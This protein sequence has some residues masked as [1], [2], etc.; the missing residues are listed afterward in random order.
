[1]FAV[2]YDIFGTV[3]NNILQLLAGCVFSFL[4]FSHLGRADRKYKFQCCS[5]NSI[6]GILLSSLFGILLPFGPYGTLPVII[7]LYM[8]GASLA[9]I[10]PLLISNF[11][12]NMSV[13]LTEM[14]FVW[15]VNV[16][17]IVAAYAA[18]A[19]AGMVLTN[20]RTDTD[21][22]L[23]ENVWERFVKE[24]RNLSGFLR[25]FGSY[26]SS[27]GLLIVSG[28]VLNTLFYRYIFYFLLNQIYSSSFGS[29]AINAF[30]GVDVANAMFVA[31]G[32]VINRLMDFTALLAV[33]FL[34]R[35][36]S[37][38]CLYAYYSIIAGILTVSILL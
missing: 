35:L 9:A 7:G 6:S 1:M 12:F 5:F 29:N 8:S 30:M 18:G 34:L 38:L 15:E 36:K 27:T 2:I 3:V 37:M 4:L 24:L 20:S 13:P 17:R 16:L 21:K 11:I 26:M 10:L 32:Q 28:A 23:R 25:M 14:N 22:I 31:A 33:A 19:V